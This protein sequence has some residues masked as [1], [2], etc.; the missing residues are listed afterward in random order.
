MA[1]TIYSDRKKSKVIAKYKELGYGIVSG[2][3]NPINVGCHFM[4]LESG[5]CASEFELTRYHEGHVMLAH[6]GITAAILDETMGYACHVR[7]YLDGQGYVPVF[8]GTVTYTYRK[9][10]EVGKKMHVFAKAEKMDDRRY[11]ITG[12]ILDDDNVVYVQGDAV[13]VNTQVLE[14]T[15]VA[16]GLMDSEPGDPEEM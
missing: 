6:G 10:V 12:E 15:H 4:V 14:K 7:Q 11:H 5:E 1:K 3:Q 9:P 16:V 2:A 13:Y 8:T